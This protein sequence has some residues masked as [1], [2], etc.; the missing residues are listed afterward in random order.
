MNRNMTKNKYSGQALAIAMLILVVS[1]LIGLAMYSRTTK[2]KTLTLEERASAEALE[3]SDVILNA[4][5]TFT[6]EEIVGS[7]DDFDESEGAV[8]YENQYENQRVTD[9]T[10]L[11]EKLEILP[12]GDRLSDL[13]GSLCPLSNVP[14]QYEL[15]LEKT[16]PDVGYELRPGHVWALP[17]WKLTPANCNLKLV[18]SDIGDPLAGFVLTKLNCNYNV[19]TDLAEECSDDYS[20]EYYKFKNSSNETYGGFLDGYWKTITPGESI[21]ISL[22]GEDS[23]PA[24]IRIKALGRLGSTGIKIFYEL[25]GEEG[26]CPSNVSMYQMRASAN[27]SGVYRGKEIVIP[28]KSHN[29]LFDY[30]YFRGL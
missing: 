16:P 24:E 20:M 10:D 6:I 9:I 18:V 11:F 4:L 27:C 17:V 12:H 1:S 3:V 2:D 8:L 22:K 23:P 26:A 28:Q 13:L 29:L 19:E 5:T 25:E 30:V 7:L 14:N 15:T 21:D